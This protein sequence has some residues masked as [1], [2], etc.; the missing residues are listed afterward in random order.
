MTVGERHPEV[1]AAAAELAALRADRERVV[2]RMAGPWWVDVTLGLA[3]W[4]A[5]EE[6][7]TLIVVG[8]VVPFQAAGD[9]AGLLPFIETIASSARAIP[10]ST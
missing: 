2:Q 3:V 5:R 8:L 7:L 10:Y 4:A 9:T 1:G 6:S